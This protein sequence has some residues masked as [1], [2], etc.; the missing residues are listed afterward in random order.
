LGKH[1]ELIRQP[2]LF[3]LKERASVEGN[4]AHDLG[5][6]T[7][8][9]QELGTVERVKTA[10]ND[11]GGVPEV[12]NPG[13]THDGL[14]HKRRPLGQLLGGPSDLTQVVPTATHTGY[15]LLG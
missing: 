3:G 14:S 13:G 1:G 15:V 9:G 12:M 6:Y 5:R 10:D 11:A 4:Q 7:Q 8:Q 2:P